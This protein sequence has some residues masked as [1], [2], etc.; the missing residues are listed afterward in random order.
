MEIED[1]AFSG[2]LQE[3]RTPLLD[4]RI[5]KYLLR[6]PPVPWCVNKELLRKAMEGHLPQ[7]VLQRPKTVLL[8]DPL[9]AS[10]IKRAWSPAIFQPLAGILPYVNWMKYIE[11]LQQAKGSLT[12]ENL[13][14]MA[15]A[16]WLKD[17]E[18]E[19]GIT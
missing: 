6:V 5:L 3:T 7:A 19:A 11:T 13:S 8:M 9:E 17:V 14:A 2:V 15:L 18:N 10:K 16:R 12:A 1:A 4:L